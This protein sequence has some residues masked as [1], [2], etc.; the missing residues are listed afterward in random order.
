[1]ATYPYLDTC[2]LE[3]PDGWVNAWKFENALMKCGDALGAS[4]NTI[5]IKVP[6]GC[7]L[8][9]DV[10]RLFLALFVRSPRKAVNG[11]RRF[12]KSGHLKFPSL[13]GRSVP[14]INRDGDRAF[15]LLAGA[16]AVSARAAG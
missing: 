4:Y 11:H 12:R 16:R 13:A 1:M 9:I 3:L 10:V 8:M 6:A 5:V 14:V 7:K 15:P 2:T